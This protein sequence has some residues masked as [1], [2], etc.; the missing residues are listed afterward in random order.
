MKDV[1]QKKQKAFTLVELLMSLM[2]LGFLMAAVAVAFDASIT[3]YQVNEGIYRAAN[4]GRQALLRITNDIRTAQSVKIF[5][6]GGDTSL[7]NLSLTTVNGEE[8]RYRF[9]LPTK[10]LYLDNITSGSS[11]VLCTNV[12]AMTFPRATVPGSSPAAIRNVRILMTLDDADSNV[13]QTLAAAA[14]VRRNL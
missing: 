1:L 2:I 10:T 3:N 5:G 9:D 13:S 14:V 11:N 8:I 7:S 4:T 12:S 6:P